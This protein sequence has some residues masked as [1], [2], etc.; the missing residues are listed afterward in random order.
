MLVLVLSLVEC[1][2]NLMSQARVHNASINE[3][4]KVFFSLQG[5]LGP[6]SQSD[7]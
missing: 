4:K 7:L 1:F 6:F 3:K 5:G 2:W